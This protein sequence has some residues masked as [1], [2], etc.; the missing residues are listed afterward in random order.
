MEALK[1]IS[2]INTTPILFAQTREDPFVEINTIKE[3]LFK[4]KPLNICLIASA[5]DT[6]CSLIIH[7]SKAEFAKIDAVDTNSNQ[8]HLAKLKLALIQGFSGK[9][10]SKI[11]AGKKKILPPKNSFYVDL[12][13]DLFNN[14]LIDRKTYEYWLENIALL[15]AGINQTGRFEKLFEICQMHHT[16]KYF[17]HDF[18]TSVFGENA[19]KYSMT[20]TFSDHFS[21]VFNKY[22][23]LYAN[24]ADNYFYY[25]VKY[26]SYPINGDMPLYLTTNDIATVTYPICFYQNN[27]L[28][29]L[30]KQND[31]SYDLVHLSNITDWLAP[32]K[33]CD[34]L[35][36]VGRTL[37]TG[38]K[39]TL[40]RLNSSTN[41]VDFIETVYN[42]SGK[43]KFTITKN[44]LDRSYFYSEVI[45][46]TKNSD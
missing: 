43:Y 40:R 21:E 33:F 37:V 38:G 11:L 18:L 1:E 2:S 8:I 17:S 24:P 15:E 45:V 4:Q 31:G 9:I 32:D 30:T 3:L 14:K 19:T 23:E 12:L 26:G 35:D 6:L 41:L 46:L 10:N 28:D 42:R 36:Q 5:G 29:H 44:V 34:L 39:A 27:M 16:E 7:E 20:K 22:K 13:D 25:Q